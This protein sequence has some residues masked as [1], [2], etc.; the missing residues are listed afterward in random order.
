MCEGGCGNGYCVDIDVCECLPLYKSSSAV[1]K[2]D[3]LECS[4][5][6]VECVE[7][8]L[9]S[10]LKCSIGTYLNSDTNKCGIF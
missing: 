4:Y 10:C 3:S 7:C 5:Y 8:N 2:C 1:S 9:N 6:D